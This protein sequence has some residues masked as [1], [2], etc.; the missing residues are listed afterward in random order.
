ML[1][2]IHTGVEREMKREVASACQRGASPLL[3]P[4]RLRP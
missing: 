1:G 3:S 4:V 2:G